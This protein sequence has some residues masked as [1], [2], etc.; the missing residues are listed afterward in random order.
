MES[1]RASPNDTVESLD[2]AMPEAE[3]PL[4]F[5]FISASMFLK[6]NMWNLLLIVMRENEHNAAIKNEIIISELLGVDGLK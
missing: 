6:T 4:S 5:S 3:S 1:A 2:K